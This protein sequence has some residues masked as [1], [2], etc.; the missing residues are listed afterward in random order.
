M[1]RHYESRIFYFIYL[2]IYFL[3]LLLFTYFLNKGMA[4]KNVCMPWAF[5]PV[6]SLWVPS[7]QHFAFRRVL[8]PA[9]ILQPELPSSSSCHLLELRAS[10]VV[11]WLKKGT[12]PMVNLRKILFFVHF[13][14]SLVL[15]RV[16]SGVTWIWTTLARNPWITVT[17]SLSW[18]APPQLVVKL[19]FIFTTPR[20][21]E[22]P[23][24]G[25]GRDHGWQAVAPPGRRSSLACYQKTPHCGVV[26]T[27]RHYGEGVPDLEGVYLHNVAQMLTFQT[28]SLGQ[29]AAHLPVILTTKGNPNKN[30][31]LFN[32]VQTYFGGRATLLSGGFLTRGHRTLGHEH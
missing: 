14:F 32:L 1:S 28:A 23:T 25:G 3:S 10:V 30:N 8:S 18:V 16:N 5:P 19:N 20:D 17:L 4:E 2:F 26:V 9:A 31:F 24:F 6:G 7:F 27:W 21:G 13:L 22:I 12:H 15:V 29:T 11:F